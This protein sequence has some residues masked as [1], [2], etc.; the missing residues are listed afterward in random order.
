MQTALGMSVVLVLVASS[1]SCGGSGNSCNVTAMITPASASADPSAAP[2]GNQVQFSL[3]SSVSGNCP[4]IADTQG[5]WS[6][7]DTAITSI[8]QQ[9]LAICTTVL[10]TS[11]QATISNSGT[12]TGHQF[13]SATLTC[14]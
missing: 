2:P 11:I 10:P 9:G 3:K 12:V 8:S 14:Q 6:T 1:L 4:L 5:V 13:K 7:S